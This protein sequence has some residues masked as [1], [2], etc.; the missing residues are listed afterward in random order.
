MGNRLTR[1]YTRTGDK[2][3]TGLA[4]GSRV[5]KDSPRIEALG[6]LDELNARVGW[7]MASDLPEPIYVT[8]ES[9]QHTL[10]DLGGEICVPGRSVIG[11]A[12][13]EELEAELDVVNADLPPLREFIL[14]GGGEE[15]SRCHLVRTACREAERR[16]VTLAR[17]EVINPASLAYLNRLSD[18]LFVYCRV[19]ARL[20]DEGEVLWEP[21]RNIDEGDS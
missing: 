3:S 6:A 10:F 1:I 17:E 9:I 4:D 11:D 14:P 20:S 16:L 21:T 15:A 5:D 19:L 2:G 7:L 13:V 12:R 18:L 8:L